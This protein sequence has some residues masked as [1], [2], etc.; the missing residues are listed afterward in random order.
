MTTISF[1][2]QPTVDAQSAGQSAATLADNFDTFLSILTA[3]IQNQDPLEPM[4][5]TEFTNQLVQ[6]SGV[7]QQIRA[8]KQL[9]TLI[10]ATR[11]TAGAALA[12]YL[13][14]EAEIG[15]A[16]AAFSGAPVNWRYELQ[17]EAAK[18]TVTVTD[19][20]GKVLYAE[21]AKLT[22]GAH[23][24]VWDGRLTKGGKAANGPYY[25]N[26]VAEDADGAKVS[27][28]HTLVTRITGVDL[29]HSEPALATDAGVY[30]Y[31]DILR[32]TGAD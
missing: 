19:A 21:P 31:A 13:G 5:S 7:E 24:F 3:Q 29:S 32:L 16:G 30:A 26:V 9:E 23:D 20:Q 6:F 12:S 1:V 11:S 22:D 27:A 25:I 4:D 14:Q 17:G 15:S 28:A 8:N 10:S 18:A 2:P